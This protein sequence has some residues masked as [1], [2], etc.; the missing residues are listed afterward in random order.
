MARIEPRTV[1]VRDARPCAVTP[2]CSGAYRRKRREVQLGVEIDRTLAR[3]RIHGQHAAD[4]HCRVLR[5]HEE[6]IN[7]ELLVRVPNRRR[8]VGGDGLAVPRQRHLLDGCGAFAACGVRE[9]APSVESGAYASCEW[10]I[11]VERQRGNV[12]IVDQHAQVGL[13]GS[14]GA[15]LCLRIDTELVRTRLHVGLLPRDVRIDRQAPKILTT[16]LQLCRRRS[17][18][19]PSDLRA[20]PGARAS[21]SN[22]PRIGYSIG[23]CQVHQAQLFRIQLEIERA[24]IQM[25][26][27]ARRQRAVAI[28]LGLAQS[29]FAQT[30]VAIDELGAGSQR[31]HHFA[32][33]G[34]IGRLH[35]QLRTR[36]GKRA[37]RGRLQ[38]DQ[39]LSGNVS[40]IECTPG[41]PRYPRV[42]TSHRARQVDDLGGRH[43]RSPEDAPLARP[44]RAGEV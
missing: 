44:H 32:V 10:R 9:T 3:L 36:I 5:S 4:G 19:C 22:A 25:V 23:E 37:R 1:P 39:T 18:P 13:I 8:S 20:S 11:Q 43:G 28:R 42:P 34:E 33:C 7:R 15:E 2:Y 12:E 21:R 27:A 26:R 38:R 35:G 14:D 16:N 41:A 30:N 17:A 29:Q 40:L 6:A 24:V 31:A